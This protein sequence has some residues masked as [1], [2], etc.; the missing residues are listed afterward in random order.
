MRKQVR[1][2]LVLAQLVGCGGGSGSKSFEGDA[3][4]PLDG[5]AGS[6]GAD[7]S[8]GQAG[9]GQS[10]SGGGPS[11][12]IEPGTPG[13]LGG[14]G[15][16]IA[17]G[18]WRLRRFDASVND[19]AHGGGLFVAV[20][21]NGMVYQSRDGRSWSSRSVA[22]AD[23]WAVV[24]HA[25]AFYIAGQQTLLRSSDAKTWMPVP[26]VSGRSQIID[27]LSTSQGL[28]LIGIGPNHVS[29]LTAAQWQTIEGT[30]TLS[31]MFNGAARGSQLVVNWNK[32]VGVSDDGKAF[33]PV[34]VA[35]GVSVRRVVATSDAYVALTSNNKA[36]SSSDGRTWTP[37]ADPPAKGSL[38]A[39]AD[40]ELVAGGDNGELAWSKD[41]KA[42]FVPAQRPRFQVKHLL[43]V[44]GSYFAIGSAVSSS[45]DKISWS[46]VGA[47]DEVYFE[48]LTFGAG[49]FVAVG[50]DGNILTSTDGSTWMRRAAEVNDRLFGVVHGGD[51]FVAVAQRQRVLTSPDGVTWTVRALPPRPSGEPGDLRTVVFGDGRFAIGGLDGVVAVSSDGIAWQWVDS[52][53]RTRMEDLA[54]HKGRFFAAT[55]VNGTSY[56]TASDDTALSWSTKVIEWGAYYWL[57]SNGKVLVSPGR[58]S[59]NVSEDG[60][61]WTNKPRSPLEFTS[62]NETQMTALGDT[63]YFLGVGGFATSRDGA[64]YEEDPTGW[65][66]QMNALAEGNGIR[67]AVGESGVVLTQEAKP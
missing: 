1:L 9:G 53:A 20:G 65:N 7:A 2:V 3:D 54:F 55:N 33:E 4:P 34:T 48:G 56:L 60:I 26:T 35:N 30:E 43:A 57:A 52:Q 49:R 22:R 63:F 62:F 12:S 17:A 18:N 10:G 23:L 45:T 67:M 51:L 37:L 47:A 6:G 66:F 19:A 58:M 41:G 27:L 61:S 28:V 14:E 31:L 11:E 59:V 16:N 25:G 5:G 50:N 21:N 44:D 15:L 13:D 36:F 64:S 42:W 40:G 32:G 29:R 38:L 24:Y 39:Y 46:A 8:A